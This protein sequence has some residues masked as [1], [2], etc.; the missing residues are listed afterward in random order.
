M[1]QIDAPYP[2]PH[3]TVIL[4][5]PKWG[6]SCELTSTVSSMYTMSGKMYTYVKSR[7]AR[8]RLRWDFEIARD[9]ALELRA[10]L[11]IYFRLS[12]RIIDHNNE[13]W[14]GYFQNNPFEFSGSARAVNFP[15]GETMVITL[16]FEEAE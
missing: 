8:K 13:I 11:N 5:S 3:V 12:V 6:D 9:K 1:F 15:G 7:D 2:N 4:P 10:F 14:I 16:E